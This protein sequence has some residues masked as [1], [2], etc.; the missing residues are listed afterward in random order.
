MEDE[1]A[2]LKTEVSSLRSQNAAITERL[3]ALEIKS[4]G[5]TVKSAPSSTGSDVGSGPEASVPEDDGKPELRVVKLGPTTEEG[6]DPPPADQRV[7]IRST[8][9]GVVEEVGSGTEDGEAGANE[10]KKAKELFDKKS[11]DAAISA[12]SSFLSRFPSHPRAAEA[13]FQRAVCYAMKNDPDRA[14]D[15]FDAVVTSFPQSDVAPEALFELAKLRDKRSDKAG[16]EQ[17][18]KRLLADYPKSA[19]AKRLDKNKKPDSPKKSDTT[20]KAP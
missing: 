4:G 10:L 7:R 14:E 5:L 12:Y 6:G 13:T 9:N 19:A 2:R 20:K 8:S 1:V 16:A 15:Q 17:A 3:D 11:W 18:R